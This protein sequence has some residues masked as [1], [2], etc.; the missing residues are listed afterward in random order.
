MDVFKL[1]IPTPSLNKFN[2]STFTLDVFKVPFLE[3]RS[4]HL[5]I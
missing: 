2:G 5:H 4:F 3:K 1:F